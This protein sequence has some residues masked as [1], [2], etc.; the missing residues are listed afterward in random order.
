V[1]TLGAVL[2]TLASEIFI[3]IAWVVLGKMILKNLNLHWGIPLIL[4]GFSIF[5]V[6]FY[7]P[8]ILWAGNILLERTV[9]TAIFMVTAFY[10]FWYRRP[11]AGWKHT[12]T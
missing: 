2:G 7:K 6:T 9:F 3:L 1:G 11:K 12:L 8:G 5:F 4:G 10:V